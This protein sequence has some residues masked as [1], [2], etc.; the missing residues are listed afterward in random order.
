MN[1][2]WKVLRMSG[3]F[4]FTY[5]VLLWICK[6]AW[7][8]CETKSGFCKINSAGSRTVFDLSEK[9][10]QIAEIEKAMTFPDFWKDHRQA[11][12]MSQELAELKKGQEKAAELGDRLKKLDEKIAGADENNLVAAKKEIS[13]LE[14]EISGLETEFYFSGKYDKGNALLSI[15]SGAGGQDA[16]DW[17]ALLLRMYSR[18][19][20]KR[21]WKVSVMHEHRGE[22]NGPG[23]W[24]VKNATILLKGQ[25]TYGYLKRESGVHRLVRI[26][27]F[28]AQSL[29]HTSFALV[30]VMPEEIPPEEVETKPEDLKI[31][32]FRAS[33]PGGQNVNKRE[34]AV[35][36]T[37][38]PTGLQASSQA[39][40]S[41]DANRETALKILR[42][43]LYTL[44]TQ[45]KEKERQG[46][47]QEKVAIEWGSQIRSYVMHPYQMV[48]DHR[49]GTEKT[50]I[51]KVLDGD[52]DEFIEAE[53]K[54]IPVKF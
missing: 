46:V 21:K 10:K 42:A 14:K 12:K 18:F 25:F 47:K 24:G 45:R 20:E 17:A 8:N 35:R 54:Q 5:G 2:L 4:K 34:T 39:E 19:G 11:G 51:E 28:S 23:G 6:R 38:L 1:F 48:K 7:K 40:R 41:Q 3:Y 15:Y 29:R 36:V 26:S 44:E 32:F 13:E 50:N 30:D 53:I 31:D 49:T 16:E 22:N 52:L 33:G 37:H 27:P 43:R 9:K